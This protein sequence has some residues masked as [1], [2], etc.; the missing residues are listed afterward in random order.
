VPRPRPGRA[1]ASSQ[2]RA[3]TREGALWVA[4]ERG[5]ARADRLD[6]RHQRRPG[7][8]HVLELAHRLA[9]P[10]VG[11]RARTAYLPANGSA[12]SFR[13][14]LARADAKLSSEASRYR[15]DTDSTNARA[16]ARESDGLL[17]RD[18]G[19]SL[20]LWASSA[21]TVLPRAA[22][23]IMTGSRTA[24]LSAGSS[25]STSTVSSSRIAQSQSPVRRAAVPALT[26]SDPKTVRRPIRRAI[27]IPRPARSTARLGSR[28]T[29]PEEAFVSA[30]ASVQDEPVRLRELAASLDQAQAL[31]PASHLHQHRPLRHEGVRDHGDQ[32]EPLGDPERS[33]GDL[34]RQLGLVAEQEGARQLC[35]ER[36]KRRV[37]SGLA[38]RPNRSQQRGRVAWATGVRERP[39]E[40]RGGSHDPARV[41]A[42]A[43]RVERRPARCA[44]RPRSVRPDRRTHPPAREA[45]PARHRRPPRRIACSK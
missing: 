18:R 13:A 3:I 17:V 38:A 15:A 26:K 14:P 2:R 1:R 43:M 44:R 29:S 25:W 35:V 7:D 40:E 9:R 19:R 23:S 41:A 6:V 11:P 32:A 24:A 16:R 27:A 39:P 45:R 33:I 8:A 21:T 10:G 31:V 42:A 20:S 37:R 34:D 30:R 12:Q 5:T 28:T 22:L 36:R 4:F